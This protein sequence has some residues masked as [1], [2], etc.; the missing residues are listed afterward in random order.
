MLIYY[1]YIV[2][3]GQQEGDV[4][5][6]GFCTADNTVCRAGRIEVVLNGEWGTVCWDGF[7]LKDGQV[8][9]SQLGFDGYINIKAFIHKTTINKKQN[10][11]P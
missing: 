3:A 7:G 6:T 10:V 4:R 8:I 5:L 11:F 2:L 9:C 1:L